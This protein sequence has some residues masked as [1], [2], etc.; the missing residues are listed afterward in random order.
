MSSVTMEMN[1]AFANKIDLSTP[2]NTMRELIAAEAE[3]WRQMEKDAAN[4]KMSLA[5]RLSS[6]FGRH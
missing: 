3:R 5:S 6:L 4:A 1:G 2:S